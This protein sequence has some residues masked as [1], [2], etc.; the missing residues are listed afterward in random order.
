MNFRKKILYPH[1]KTYLTAAKLISNGQLVI[2]P[3]ETVYGLGADATNNYAVA[4]IFKAKNRPK[5]NPL[6]IHVHSYKQ[7]KNFVEF[8]EISTQLAKIFWP[9]PLTLVLPRKKG[10]GISFLATSGLNS[11]AI[12]VPK[13]KI[14]QNF[15]KFSKKPIAA[16]SANAS[17]EISPT[18]INHISKSV[19]SEVSL[20]INGGQCRLGLESTILEATK[21]NLYIIRYGSLSNEEIKKKIKKN[22]LKLL[23]KKR[24][25]APGRKY[26]H[27]APNHP[28]KTNVIKL[29]K[30]QALLAFGNILPKNFKIVKNLSKKGD[31]AEAAA[32][33]F[34]M[35]KELDK[36][37]CQ[38]I[39][40]MPIPNR[41]LGRAINDRLRRALKN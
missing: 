19:I 1:K 30:N 17:G 41:G 5:F 11:I 7:A 39:A 26:K 8:D 34:D 9:G 12:R 4:K 33:F 37:K 29:K 38:S 31:L 15:L 18:N 24:A 40:V 16:P 35:L 22:K 20:I 25:T 6:I 36:S 10:A 2:F 28:L 27:Y 23:Y 32:N 14:A 13:N 3:T 21:K